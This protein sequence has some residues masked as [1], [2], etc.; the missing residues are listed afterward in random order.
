M[1]VILHE[2]QKRDS[3]ELRETDRRPSIPEIFFVVQVGQEAGGDPLE[4]D[5]VV[6]Q[7][8]GGL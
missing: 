1:R 6:D 3:T 8:G 7:E 5:H 2:Y 4:L